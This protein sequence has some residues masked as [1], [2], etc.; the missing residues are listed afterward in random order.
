MASQGV[1][2]WWV[3]QLHPIVRY[4]LIGIDILQKEAQ[5]MIDFAGAHRSD[6]NLPCPGG[7]K[8][9]PGFGVI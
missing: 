7:G 6:S 5:S 9:S 8:I 4:L 1:I 2:F 3:A